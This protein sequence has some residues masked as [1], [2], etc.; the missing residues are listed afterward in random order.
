[1]MKMKK[2]QD[3]F[4]Q[5]PNDQLTQNEIMINECILN[6]SN[7][8][9]SIFQWLC[10]CIAYSRMVYEINDWH[11]AQ[12][13]CC[14]GY[15]YINYKGEKYSLQAENHAENSMKLISYS[16]NSTRQQINSPISDDCPP[17]LIILCVILL[18]YYTLAKSSII[19]HKKKTALSLIRQ[20][21]NALN[22]VEQLLLDFIVNSKNISE[23]SDHSE[24]NS[25]QFDRNLENY[26]Q[27]LNH[28]TLMRLDKN[29][30]PDLKILKVCIYCLYGKIA[31]ECEKQVLS[32]DQYMHALKLIEAIYGSNSKETISLYHALGRIKEYQTSEDD[33]KE[34]L[35]YFKKACEISNK[36]YG[37]TESFSSMVDLIRSVYLLGTVY[38]KFNLNFDESELHV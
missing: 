27:Q 22:Q 21:E 12:Y 8:H 5:T 20:A 1:M 11:H 15:F 33:M 24:E 9:D 23:N 32:F 34:S 4:L 35:G 31:F 3:S 37:E 28:C 16:L 6:C 30:Y 26:Y 2:K 19:L 25:E 29:F 18:N 36:V 14:L 38:M 10:E 7:K 13:Q 17:N